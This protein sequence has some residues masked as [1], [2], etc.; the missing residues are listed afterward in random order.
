VCYSGTW[1]VSPREMYA[2]TGRTVLDDGAH[3]I[4]TKSVCVQLT[5]LPFAS[6]LIVTRILLQLPTREAKQAAR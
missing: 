4:A 5:P 1:L 3:L 2:V 6:A